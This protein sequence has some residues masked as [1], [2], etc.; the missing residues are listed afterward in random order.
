MYFLSEEKYTP[1]LI[2]AKD[3]MLIIKA[4]TGNS[5]LK[6]IVYNVLFNSVYI[7]ILKQFYIFWFISLLVTASGFRMFN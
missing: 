6:I 1:V 2:C 5:F 7:L 4:T 3:D